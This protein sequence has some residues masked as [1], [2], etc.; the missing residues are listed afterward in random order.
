MFDS[1][2]LK[3]TLPSIRKMPNPKSSKDSKRKDS[4]SVTAN[5]LSRRL[6]VM[7]WTN[8]GKSMATIIILL[9]ITLRKATKRRSRKKRRIKLKTRRL[10]HS[11]S[12]ASDMKIL[13]NW[14]V[15]SRTFFAG[16]LTTFHWRKANKNWSESCCHTTIK[17]PRRSRTWSTLWL[18]FTQ[19]TL[20]PGVCLQ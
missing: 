4:K 16:T 18:T 7:L 13:T 19:S 8:S 14:R 1:T 2:K 17:E 5:W 11:I 9:L 10:R 12:V 15:F 20:T 6:K 3:V